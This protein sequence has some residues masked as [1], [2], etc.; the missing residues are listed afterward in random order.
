M[1][2]GEPRR[3]LETL[4]PITYVSTH[5]DLINEAPWLQLT[6]TSNTARLVAEQ[7]II[8]DQVVVFRTP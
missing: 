6:D 2:Q 1:L 8:D 3:L 7:V 5:T 4:R